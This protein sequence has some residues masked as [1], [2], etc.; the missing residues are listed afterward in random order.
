M[1]VAA[2][3]ALADDADTRSADVLRLPQR[4]GADGGGE[5]S[6][7]C[8]PVRDRRGRPQGAEDREP[9]RGADLAGCVHDARGGTGCLRRDV[10]HGHVG[11]AGDEEAE[12]RPAQQV[13]DGGH[14]ERRRH[15][16]QAQREDAGGADHA[17]GRHHPGDGVTAVEPSGELRREQERGVHEQPGQAGSQWRPAVHVLVQQGDV[18]QDAAEGRV[19]DEVDGRGA[20]EAAGAQQRRRDHRVRA[21]A[22]PPEEAREEDHA[23]G[24]RRRDGP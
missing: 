10:A 4:V 22:L 5:A 16:G 23:D 24:D 2:A 8:L 7:G 9:D 15:A 18:E 14:D 1:P 20:D 11:D 17:A 19:A 3:E 6:D 12:A 21:A 13:A